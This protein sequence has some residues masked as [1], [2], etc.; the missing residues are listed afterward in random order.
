MI[1]IGIQD[2]ENIFQNT[3]MR[4]QIE[5]KKSDDVYIDILIDEIQTYFN[6]LNSFKFD[7]NLFL[8]YDKIL[9][10]KKYLNMLS[11]V[12]GNITLLY[13]KSDQIIGEINKLVNVNGYERDTILKKLD[14]IHNYLIAHT[15]ASEQNV[16]S[17]IFYRESFNDTSMEDK[18]AGSKD[19]EIDTT[20]GILK[21]KSEKVI[22][23]VLDLNSVNISF[24]NRTEFQN[25]LVPDPSTNLVVGDL[26]KVHGETYNKSESE[27]RKYMSDDEETG[28]ATTSCPF[29][30][31]FTYTSNF[32]N[33]ITMK[34]QI[35]AQTKN[36]FGKV[37]LSENQSFLTRYMNYL[38]PFVDISPEIVLTFNLSSPVPCSFIDIKFDNEIPALVKDGTNL[39]AFVYDDK[40]TYPIMDYD[41]DSNKSNFPVYRLYWGKIINLAR[42]EIHFKLKWVDVPITMLRWDTVF[43]NENTKVIKVFFTEA[44]N[45]EIY[46]KI[47]GEKRDELSLSKDLHKLSMKTWWTSSTYSV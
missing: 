39:K 31:V 7:D 40:M 28:N 13:K 24:V 6:N 38:T 45:S 23:K 1:K 29:E 30:I 37:E 10:L 41:V 16:D 42:A 47:T 4:F 11:T 32:K 26:Y 8:T 43:I 33:E 15:I 35:N 27:L 2:L 25:K 36:G 34:D 9:S 22:K 21:L 46:S 20:A 14:K 12:S 19:V 18:N 3:R 17:S 5:K 44:F